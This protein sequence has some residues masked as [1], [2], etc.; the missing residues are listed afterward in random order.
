WTKNYTWYD[1]KG[2]VIGSHSINHLGGY[3]KTESEL[4]F[5]GV[6]QQ[7]ITRHKRLD[8][9]AEKVITE[10]FT[11]DHQNRLL[12]HKH[13]VDNNPVEYLTQ[14]EYNELSQLKNKKVGGTS[15]GSGLQSVDYAYNIRGWMTKINDPANL[16]DKL[17]GYEMKYVNPAS[18]GGRYNGNITSVDWKKSITPGE[19]ST[20]R[21]YEYNYDPLNRLTEASFST[22]DSAV[23]TNGFFNEQVQYDLNGNLTHLWRTA[24]SFYGNSAELV[25]NLDY[26]YEGN[27]LTRIND[28]TGNPTGYE[29]GNNTNGYDANGNLTSMPDKKIDDIR[30]N[31]L[32]LPYQLKIDNYNKSLSYLY[33]ADGTKLK[34][35]F[36]TSNSNGAMYSSSTEY[37][38]GFH[39]ASSTGDEL[40]WAWYK[41]TGEAYEPEAFINMIHGSSYNSVLKFLPTSE[42]FYDFENNEYIYQY[43]D[44]LGNVR[45]SYKN[46]IDNKLTVTDSNDYYPFGMNFIRNP[47]AEAYF[48]TGSYKN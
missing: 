16:N 40:W 27:M 13:Q 7:A 19:E 26:Y 42:G 29:G 39:Y 32:N 43:K 15:L 45:V 20:L 17:F 22:P 31:Y 8:S 6:P 28:G 11:Y 4:D 36:I 34:K 33:R 24:P 25:D 10:N 14:N 3:T 18:T 44:H 46:G 5:A 1:T 38:D 37:L 12:T 23:P 48:G 9:D 2:R 35:S 41:E 47:E 21:R 30:Y